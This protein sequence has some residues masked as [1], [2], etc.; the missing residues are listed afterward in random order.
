MRV[1][2]VKAPLG[3]AYRRLWTSSG[4]SNLA[5]GVVKVVLPL[6]AI[7]FADVAEGLR[8][9]GRHRLLRTMA[10]MVGVIGW[11]GCSGA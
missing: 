6:V 2:V 4:L 5:D 3:A 8:F 7:R 10:V 11:V 1:V 9:L